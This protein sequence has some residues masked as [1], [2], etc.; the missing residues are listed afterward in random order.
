MSGL[1]HALRKL[2]WIL[3]SPSTILRGFPSKMIVMTKK[4]HNPGINILITYSITNYV[5]NIFI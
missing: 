2:A 3:Y 4:I 5:V 1:G